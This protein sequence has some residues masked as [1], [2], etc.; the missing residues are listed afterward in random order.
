[1]TE[2]LIATAIADKKP[3][4]LKSISRARKKKVVD[5]ETR[6]YTVLKSSIVKVIPQADLDKKLFLSE[7][8]KMMGY[9][10]SYYN[11][12]QYIGFYNV[13]LTIAFTAIQV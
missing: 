5:E 2:N 12:R 11:Q 1:M 6:Q 9:A 7:F 4:A 8:L 10:D 13:G 3:N